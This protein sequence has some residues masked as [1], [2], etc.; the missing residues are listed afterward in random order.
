[1]KKDRKTYRI[2]VLAA[3]CAV[4]CAVWGCRQEDD[5][6]VHL[7]KIHTTKYKIAV[8][9]PLNQNSDYQTRL[10]NTI[11]W[12][13]DN[14][15][16]AQKLVLENGDTTAVDL[17]IEWHDEEKEDLSRLADSLATRDDILLTIGPLTNADVDLMAP[18]FAKHDKPLIVPCASSES[19]IRRYSVGTAG[20]ENKKPFLWSLCETDVSQSEAIL[21]KAWEGGAKTIALL[22][23]DDD[24]GKTF[25]EWMPF[26]ATEMGM[27]LKLNTQYADNSKLAQAAQQVLASGVDCAVC[28]VESAGEARTVLEARRKMGDKAPRVIFTNGA[29]SAALLQMGDLAEGAEGVAPYA[30]PTTGFQIAYEQKF[31][32]TPAGAEAQVYDALMLAGF[33]AFT[34]RHLDMQQQPMSANE[35]LRSI[36]SVGDEPYPVWNELGI[37]SLLLLLKEGRRV[38]LVG[39]SGVLRFDKE[40]YTS[41]I[42]STYVHWM[43]YGGKILAID[44]RSSDGNNRVAST[45][46]SW[47]WQARQQQTI[48]DSDVD[49]AYKPLK[50]RWAVLIQGSSQWRNYRHQADVLNMYQMLKRNGWDDDHI[51]LIISDDIAR[52]SSNKYRGKVMTSADGADL[53][54]TARIDYST[55]T[56]SLADISDILLGHRSSHLPTV[57]DTDDSSNVLVFW[58]GH[59]GLTEQ[60]YDGDGFVWRDTKNV[61]STQRL[62]QTLT[63]MHNHARYRKMLMFFE[64]C[65]SELMAQQTEGLPG[66]LAFASA[67][68]GE[69][70]FAD[71]HSSELA[72]WMSDRFSNNIVSLLSANPAATYR[73]LYLYLVGHTLGSHVHVENATNFDNLYTASPEE[74]LR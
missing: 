43:V 14:L 21:A 49:I 11:N 56:L 72:V 1:M 67:S 41:L 6:I 38:K 45:L 35:I 52:N 50:N 68:A 54:S 51:I 15:R 28:A 39:A 16:G 7:T 53:Y 47:N 71:Y 46:A 55:D 37:R 40:A 34:K 73:E 64:P 27:S 58:S 23:P 17:D 12:A 24:Y 4:L 57:L 26:Q 42:E 10:E 62:R 30:D 65:Y 2:A 19:I 25:F 63:E 13:L 69:Q 18:S 5:T 61:F 31:G 44:Y 29:L 70:S 3:L 60:L 66:I 59:G 22:S 33:T 9:L 74:F 20:V 48:T 36:T 32:Y 8:V